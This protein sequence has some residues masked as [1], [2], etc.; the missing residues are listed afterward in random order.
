MMDTGKADRI[1]ANGVKVVETSGWKTRGSSSF[2]PFGHV[3]HHTATTTL[4]LNTLINGRSDLPGPLCTSALDTDGTCYIIAAGRANHAGE[5]GWNGLTGNSRMT[6]LE[7]THPGTYPLPDNLIEVAIRIG[8]A[9]L[10]APGSSRDAS[11]AC[12]HYEWAPKRKIDVATM[13]NPHEW[14]QRTAYWIGRDAGQPPPTSE[15]Q[16][17]KPVLI[18]R[19]RDGAIFVYVDGAKKWMPNWDAIGQMLWNYAASGNPI[20]TQANNQP[21]DWLDWQVDMIPPMAPSYAG[22]PWAG[23]DFGDP[24]E[25]RRSRGHLLTCQIEP[26]SK[27]DFP[28]FIEGIHYHAY[29]ADHDSDRIFDSREGIRDEETFTTTTDLEGMPDEAPDP[30]ELAKLD[31]ELREGKAA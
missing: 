31:A 4:P 21:W 15:V 28:A 16:D 17:M 29:N 11:Y 20:S 3:Y 19:P 23:D 1:R 27:F 24:E 9:E 30:S 22:A 6:G 2:T 10:E 8:A 12:Q 14:R 7:I 5:G 18:R 26:Y 13:T 25:Y